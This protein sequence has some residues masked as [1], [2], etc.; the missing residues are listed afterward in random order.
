MVLLALLACEPTPSGDVAATTDDTSAAVDD[1]VA[2]ASL[3]ISEVNATISEHIVTVARV[4]WSTDVPTTGYVEFG[5]DESYGHVT[6][7]TD[8]GTEHEVLLLGMPADTEIHFRVV[9]T[10]GEL[11]GQTAD[12]G[13]TTGSLPSGTPILTITGEVADQ[14]SYQAIPFQGTSYVIAIIDTLGR[15][16]WYDFPEANGNLMR[17]LVSHDRSE[18]VY[19]WAGSSDSL[20]EGKIVRVSMD[21]SEREEISFPYVDHDAALLPDGTIAA[22]VVT[23][24]PEGSEFEGRADADSIVEMAPDGTLTTIWNAWDH[25]DFEALQPIND[26]N[27]THANGLDYVAEEDAYYIALKTLGSIAK[28]DRSTGETQWFIN[29]QLNEFEFPEGTEIV[30]IQHQFERLDGGILIFDNGSRERGYSR[31]VELVFDEETLQA[32]EVWEYIRDPSVQVQ[33]KGDV[34]RFDDGTTQVVWSINGE[35]QNVTPEG[36]VFWQLNTELGQAL[37]FVQ[38]VD[39]LYVRQ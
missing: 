12:A 4:S 31:A 25:I 7:T 22:I 38:L 24:P 10:D 2:E 3:V 6:N 35:I 26:H 8:E 15:I 39:D 20:E 28:V 14:W 5:F 17:S 37:T 9:A 19:V 13:V 29:G 27:W 1:S 23:E 11:S 32:E 34:A 30:E 18:V 36:E 33:A 21:G 16:V